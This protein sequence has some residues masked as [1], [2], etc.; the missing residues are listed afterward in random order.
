MAYLVAWVQETHECCCQSLCGPAGDQSLCLPVHLQAS[1]L[2][3]VASHCLAQLGDSGKGWVPE[4]QPQSPLPMEAAQQWLRE[5]LTA[6]W[7]TQLGVGTGKMVWLC[8]C[9]VPPASNT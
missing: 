7:C 5:L 9:L 3:A 4:S 8:C 2:L 1:K 6:A